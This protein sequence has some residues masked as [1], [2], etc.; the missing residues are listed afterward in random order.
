[1]RYL[2]HTEADIQAMLAA[3]GIRDMDDLFSHIPRESRR[4]R[5]MVLPAA[6]TE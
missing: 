6:F 2:P 1:M 3:V 5:P 4:K